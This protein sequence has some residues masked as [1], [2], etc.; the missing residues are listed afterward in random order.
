M[1]ENEDHE[2]T[3]GVQHCDNIIHCGEPKV[4]HISRERFEAHPRAKPVCNP[5][6]VKIS[7]L[8]DWKL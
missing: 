4:I 5:G 7:M 6:N 1:I 8:S 3:S 2:L